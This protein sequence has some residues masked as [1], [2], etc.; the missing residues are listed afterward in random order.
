MKECVVDI[1]FSVSRA[2]IGCL[3]QSRLLCL[4]IAFY[5]YRFLSLSTPAYRL[6]RHVVGCWPAEAQNEM[7]ADVALAIVAKSDVEDSALANLSALILRFLALFW[8][9]RQNLIVASLKGMPRYP[10][11]F[12]VKRV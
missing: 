5:R 7:S 3:A 4:F 1:I 10:A 12:R 8:T 2:Q 9:V 6:Q 11:L